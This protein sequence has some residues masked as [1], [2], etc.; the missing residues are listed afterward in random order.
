MLLLVLL[1]FALRL[2]RLDSQPLRGDESF[3]IQFSAH[4]LRWLVPSIANVEPNPPLYYFVLHYWMEVL[5]QSEFITR[6]LSLVFGVLA[7]PAIYRLGNALGRP[8]VGMLAAF[9]VAINPFQIWHA[10]DVRNYTIWPLLSIGGLIFL[11]YALR[12]G[13]KRYWAGYAAMTILSLYTHYYDLFMLLVQ[14]VFVLILILTGWHRGETLGPSRRRLLLTWLAIQSLLAVTYVPWLAYGS[15]R[16]F[17]Y[18]THA[19][20]PPLWAVFSRSL[21]AF[22][23]GETVPRELA[24]VSLPF[25]LAL[26]LIGLAYALR[27]DRFVG[28][29]LI[30]YVVVPSICIFITAQVRP[31][32]RERYLNVVAPAYYLGISYGLLAIRNELPRWKLAPLVAGVGLLALGSAYSLSNHYWNPAY[33]KSP[34]WRAMTDHLAEETEPG[35]VIVLNYP[36]PTFSYYYHGR[37]PSSILP[38]EPLSEEIAAE[39]AE[40]LRFLSERHQRI[41]FYPLEDVAWDNESFVETWLNRH[42]RLIEERNIVGF[43]WLI[44]EPITV[45]AEDIENPMALALGDAIVLRGS[46]FEGRQPNGSGMIPVEPGSSLRFS[47][48]WEAVQNVDTS[49]TVFIH[50]VDSE[51]HIWSQRDS[52]PQDGDFPTNEWM[53]GDIVVDRYSILV[54]PDAPPG[55]Y[56]LVAG[57]YDTIDGRRLPVSDGSAIAQGDR[58]TIAIVR[59][60]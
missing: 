55:T 23:L 28:L 46:E 7:V 49:Y 29:F 60:G 8:K 45:S 26:L 44:Y 19:D 58:A 32:F 25:L 24:A 9:L 11:V 57:M 18:T 56:V 5:G 35:D 52:L 30:L 4:S 47:L 31:L 48:Y 3:T 50:L 40:A 14:N 6:F 53:E 12:T 33:S 37:A 51:D 10:Q 1:A 2:Y 27:K 43:R 41:W 42:G 38:R 16:L 17:F 36:D 54:P 22:S 39:T 13:G 59:M 34:D 20:S 15:S 21:T